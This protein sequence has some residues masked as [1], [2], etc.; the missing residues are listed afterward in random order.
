[1]ELKENM[2]LT[3]SLDIESERHPL[4][5]GER[6]V[7]KRENKRCKLLEKHIQN[8]GIIWLIKVLDS[9]KTFYANQTEFTNRIIQGA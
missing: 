6:K 8:W 1:M 7:F 9:G 2:E 5:G 4:M 3:L